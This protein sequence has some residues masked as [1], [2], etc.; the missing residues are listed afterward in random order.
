MNRTAQT[1]FA[2]AAL[3]ALLLT[4]LV[5][6]LA[7]ETEPEEPEI[8]LPRVL[9]EIEDLSVETITAGLPEDELLP[10]ELEVPLPE[11]EDLVIDEPSIMLSPPRAESTVL[12][13]EEGK[14]VNFE[15]VIGVGSRNNFMSGFSLYQFEREPEGRLVFEHEIYDGLSGFEEGTGYN[16]REDSIEGSIEFNAKKLEVE[17][18]GGFDDHERGLQGLGDYYSKISRY[19]N[20][21]GGL[22]Y[23]FGDRFSLG[24]GLGA[25]FTSQL[26][27]ASG[28][29]A[30]DSDKVR[31]YLA[32]ASL[33]GRYRFDRGYVG[34]E[35]GASYRDRAD[36][37][38]QLTRARIRGYFAVDLGEVTR[39]EGD[40]SWFWSTSS[41]HL[42]PFRLTLFTYPNDLFSLSLSGGYRL[43]EYNLH[44][45]FEYYPYAELP[46]EL[47]DDYGW[48]FDAGS[49]IHVARAW[50]LNAGISFMDAS[51]MF[52]TT[53]T[54]GPATGQF[55]VNQ[56]AAS[57]LSMELGIRWSQSTRFS[58][59]GSWI[60]DILDRPRFFPQHSFNMELNWDGRSGKYGADLTAVQTIGV[61][62]FVQAP[63]VDLSGYYRIADFI[64]LVGEANDILYPALDKPRYDWYPFVDVGLQFAFKVYINF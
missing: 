10:E 61:N 64:R 29:S 41:A 15:G 18:N 48:F 6:A 19:G 35:P 40:V 21:F 39:L 27:T 20:A 7:Q 51:G 13:R 50:V 59:Y 30:P 54:T 60:Y 24:F 25:D 62:D 53:D 34:L 9:L 55:P 26:L 32:Y 45:L 14:Y 44:Y 33:D 23:P 3:A 49:H 52:T 38:Y 31:E 17:L 36:G 37:A 4:P 63:I 2:L 58:A 8:V 57:R 5:P 42:V 16:L 22:T 56:T 46:S 11:P 43:L 47:K 12:T 1:L 28:S